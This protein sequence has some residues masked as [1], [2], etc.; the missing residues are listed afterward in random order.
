MRQSRS[1]LRRPREGPSGETHLVRVVDAQL[2]E[3]VGLEDLEAGDV[4]HADERLLAVL[5]SGGRRRRR[6]RRTCAA[7][8]AGERHVDAVDK[9]AKVLLVQ[10]LGERAE[11]GDDLVARAALD[12]DLAA[13]LDARAQ[14]RVGERVGGDAEEVRRLLEGRARRERG[15]RRAR[16][17]ERE[18]AE[19][20]DGRDRAE[21]RQLLG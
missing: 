11:L 20:E 21:Q 3:A 1:R 15:G 9:G 17:R 18:L 16:H 4:E 19:V 6:R 12:D 5:L 8:R 10:A 2:L 14:E 7:R 13:G